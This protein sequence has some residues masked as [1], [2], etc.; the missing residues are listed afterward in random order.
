MIN[1]IPSSIF[2][3]LVCRNPY[4]FFLQFD[5]N[6]AEHQP[7]A[8]FLSGKS[9]SHDKL[10][11]VLWGQLIS[12]ASCLKKNVNGSWENSPCLNTIESAN[13]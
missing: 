7:A 11:C 8:L 12:T 1:Q 2:N 4:C 5:K 6:K 9:M 13:T 3:V 10:F